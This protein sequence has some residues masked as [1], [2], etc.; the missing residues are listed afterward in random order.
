MYCSAFVRF[1]YQEADRDFV[2]A[3]VALSNTSP[4]HIAQ[5]RGF[6]AEWQA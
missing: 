3:D 2:D 5:A 6:R 1:C 4:E